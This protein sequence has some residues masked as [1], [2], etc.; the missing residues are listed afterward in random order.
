MDI[1]YLDSSGDLDES[2][3]TLTLTP[4][5][6][7]TD[8]TEWSDWLK[9]ISQIEI[10]TK[11]LHTLSDDMDTH[12]KWERFAKAAKCQAKI[13]LCE[14]YDMILRIDKVRVLYFV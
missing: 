2:Q 7:S 13:D 4:E 1:S 14:E 10:V 8:R 11:Q 9:Y 5:F 12:V 6:K 3:D